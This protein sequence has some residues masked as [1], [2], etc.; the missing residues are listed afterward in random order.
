MKHGDVTAEGKK[1][2]DGLLVSV[3]RYLRDNDPGTS[4]G[5][6]IGLGAL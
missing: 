4:C 3:R 1:V 5:R 2:T 6:R